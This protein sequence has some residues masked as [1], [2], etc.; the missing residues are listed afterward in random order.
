MA[1]FGMD[2]HDATR[3]QTLTKNIGFKRLEETG[4]EINLTPEKLEELDS[5]LKEY[6]NTKF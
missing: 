4:K 3:N 5:E 2:A 6:G 1:A